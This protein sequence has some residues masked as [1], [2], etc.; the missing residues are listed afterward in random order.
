MRPTQRSGEQRNPRLLG[1][2]EPGDA[3]AVGADGDARCAVR[4]IAV[5]V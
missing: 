3:V 4:G 5:G 2:V 1:T